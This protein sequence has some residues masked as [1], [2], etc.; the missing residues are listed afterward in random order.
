[1]REL[2]WGTSQ[3][4]GTLKT[5]PIHVVRKSTIHGGVHERGQDRGHKVGLCGL[6]TKV[7]KILVPKLPLRL[8]VDGRAG[9]A[10]LVK[11]K[12][13]VRGVVHDGALR[14]EP[15]ER[16]LLAVAR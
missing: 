16:Q 9:V 6:I 13:G 11:E 1:M 10:P 4:Q 5:H 15:L 8:I 3:G 7:P 2:F 12:V 14:L